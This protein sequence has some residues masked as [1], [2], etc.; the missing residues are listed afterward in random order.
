[1]EPQKELLLGTLLK[2]ER[3]KKGLSRDQVAQITRLRKHYIEALE[4]ENW[5]K[6]PSPVYIKGFIRSYAQSVGFSGEEAIS[7][8]EKM[9]PFEE[10][11]P[12][13]LT[14]VKQSN[15]KIFFLLLPFL[16]VLALGIYL[17]IDKR[18]H[19]PEKKDTILVVQEDQLK[20]PNLTREE[21]LSLATQEMDTALEEKIESEES[22]SYML[23]SEEDIMEDMIEASPVSVIEPPVEQ[24]ESVPDQSTQEQVAPHIDGLV[25]TGIVNMTTY[26]KIYVDNDLPKEYIFKPGSRPQWIAREGFDILVGNAAGIEFNF[27]GERVKNLGEIGKVIRV[28]FPEDFESNIYEN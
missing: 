14:G 16:A 17:W 9:A 12:K 2:G 27:N 10:S 18:A 23:F 20:E 21:D 25:L 24:I 8:Y 15:K 7:L 5:D 26:I 3:E 22:P 1:M 28:R 11:I 6:L 19:L 4:E 13:P